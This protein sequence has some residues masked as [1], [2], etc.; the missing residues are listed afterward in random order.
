MVFTLSFFIALMASWYSSLSMSFNVLYSLRIG[1][2]SVA[3][4]STERWLTPLA[5]AGT[6]SADIEDDAR[7]S[8]SGF[9]VTFTC[10][11]TSDESQSTVSGDALS[12]F[13]PFNH[14]NSNKQDVVISSSL[15]VGSSLILVVMHSFNIGGSGLFRIPQ[16]TSKGQDTKNNSS[17]KKTYWKV[18]HSTSEGF[19]KKIDCC[20]TLR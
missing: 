3:G 20:L 10:F 14:I 12:H 15:T 4:L 11:S 9:D 8:T 5:V 1:G 7:T 2:K 18:K 6:L 19:K 16:C 13:C 17:W